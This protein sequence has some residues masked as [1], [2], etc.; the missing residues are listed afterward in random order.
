[1]T[2]TRRSS[3]LVRS[4]LSLDCLEDR[5]L[6]S[7]LS[8]CTS[9]AVIDPTAVGVQDAAQCAATQTDA[10]QGATASTSS[11]ATTCPI[12]GATIASPDAILT[13]IP[14]SPAA[15]ATQAATSNTVTAAPAAPVI[16]PQLTS[17]NPAL[18]FGGDA[19][20]AESVGHAL[21]QQDG[22]PGYVTAAVFFVSNDEHDMSWVDDEAT[23]EREKSVPTGL[24]A[25]ADES[26]IKA[27]APDTTLHFVPDFQPLDQSSPFLLATLRTAE[28]QTPKTEETAAVGL[29]K[30]SAVEKTVDQVFVT[31]PASDGFSEETQSKSHSFVTSPAPVTQFIPDDPA[32]NP[33]EEDGSVESTWLQTAEI[34]IPFAGFILALGLCQD[35]SRSSLDCKVRS[36]LISR[37]KQG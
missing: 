15:D 33:G 20:T 18:L 36:A 3:R 7:V 5:L 30:D 21:T 29:R 8:G 6:L 10:T 35:Q 24:L 9:S 17:V 28:V 34:A 1:M 11:G 4:R 13:P 12:T 32:P 2:L 27:S 14:V 22:E 16:T 26:D 23:T 25:Q 37:L 31:R 19:G